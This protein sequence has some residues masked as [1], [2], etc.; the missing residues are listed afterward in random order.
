MRALESKIIVDSRYFASGEF[1][2]DIN[3][4]SKFGAKGALA[5]AFGKL[6]RALA[7]SDAAV[8]PDGFKRT[9]GEWDATF[10][11]FAQQDAAEFLMKLFD[12]LGED[13]NRVADKPYVENPDVTTDEG[14]VDEDAERRVADER[15][16]ARKSKCF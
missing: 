4:D 9:L 6:L 16:A 1:A 12:G 3:V 7:E 10:S 2:H 8:T 11:G 5:A 13:L 14:A 15:R